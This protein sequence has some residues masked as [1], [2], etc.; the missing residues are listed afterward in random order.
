MHAISGT[1]E[2]QKSVTAHEFQATWYF[3]IL[4]LEEREHTLC[5]SNH[6]NAFNS[7]GWTW[8]SQRAWVLAQAHLLPLQP[9]TTLLQ[10]CHWRCLSLQCPSTRGQKK[11][12]K[13]AGRQKRDVYLPREEVV[14][15]ISFQNFTLHPSYLGYLPPLAMPP[16]LPD[17]R[18]SFTDTVD[19]N[20]NNN[21]RCVQKLK[22]QIAQLK[23]SCSLHTAGKNQLAAVWG[24]SEVMARESQ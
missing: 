19:L 3:Q 15:K 16:L 5:L 11:N 20:S 22:V 10:L 2:G 21:N 9:C 8:S 24:T 14:R 12:K 6:S 23:N 13:E 18:C 17:S 1:L 4:I 7:S